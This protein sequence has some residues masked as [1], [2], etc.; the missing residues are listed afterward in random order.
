MVAA[1]EAPFPDESFKA[2]VAAWPLL[3]PIQPDDPGAAEMRAARKAL[4]EWQKPALILFSDSDPITAGGDL[5][6]RRLM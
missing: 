4:A 1:Y 6:F 3:V 5:W 2:G